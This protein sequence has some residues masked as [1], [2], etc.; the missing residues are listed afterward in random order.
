MDE[1]AKPDQVLVRV[2]EFST[3]NKS[4]DVELP[5][6]CTVLQLKERIAE[7]HERKPAPSH[8]R[9]RSGWQ[10]CRYWRC[11]NDDRLCCVFAL[12]LSASVLS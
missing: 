10:C 4:V 7:Q 11:A 9:V 5:P 1:I 12:K 3:G 6:G 8:Q 2:C